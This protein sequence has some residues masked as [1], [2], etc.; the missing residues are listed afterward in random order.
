MRPSIPYCYGAIL[1]GAALICL[2]V[3]A[4]GAA[5]QNYDDESTPE[6]WAW[7]LIKQG[8]EA[9]FDVRCGTPELDPRKDDDRWNGECRRLSA[10]FISDVL[11]REP[12]RSQVPLAGINIAGTRIVDGIDLKNANLNRV[13]SLTRSRIENDIDLTRARTD[14]VICLDGSR[15]AGN[16]AGDQL[17]SDSSLWLRS[18]QF[19]KAVVLSYAKIDVNVEM[20]GT[21][22]EGP[23]EAD[24]LH[25]GLNLFLRSSDNSV[26]KFNGINLRGARIDG[27][28]SM[29]GATVEGALNADS[30]HIGAHLLMR[31]T[32]AHRA[33]FK[34]VILKNATIDGQI[35]LEG[36]TLD[37]TLNGYSLHVGSDLLMQSTDAYVAAFTE[38]VLSDA[39]IDGQIIMQGTSIGGSLNADTLHVGAHISMRSNKYT[40]VFNAIRFAN[41]QVAG[42]ISIDGAV[43][44]GDMKAAGVQVGSN[45]YMRN[46]ISPHEINLTFAHVNGNLDTSGSKLGSLDLSGASVATL[47][48][49]NVE[50]PPEVTAWQGEK[51]QPGRLNLRNAHVGNLIDAPTAWPDKGYLSLAGFTFNHLG[52]LE[53]PREGSDKGKREPGR[54][55]EWL[56]RDRTYHPSSYEQLA[57]A[58]TAAGDRA[59]ADEIRYLSRIRQR[60]VTTDWW[61]RASSY[62]FQYTAGFGIGDY[63]FLV[64]A[65]VFGI[66]FAGALYLRFLVPAGR[67]HGLVWCYGASL[68]RLLPII[69]INRE[70][71]DFFNDPERKRL[72]GRDSLIFSIIAMV[73]WLLGAILIAAVSGLVPKG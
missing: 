52:G 53:E 48:L 31:S 41:A 3:G 24:S 26:G 16:L 21:T 56:R 66:S 27:Q 69:E 35:D 38:V 14:S 36:A 46:V 49:G 55:D 30:L 10:A 1:L 25:V 7:G 22:I 50:D 12:W 51:N 15:I 47:W 17:H 59:G 6:G 2:T 65:W 58:F 60:E 4:Q 44:T 5:Q 39:R 43:L 37:G 9:N 29:I 72:T 34:N 28:V 62:L 73:G 68:S 64:L 23:L 20:T 63:T 19:K 67:E 70:F 42:Q 18:S 45:L 57:A 8:K 61:P 40:A 32:D 11:M 13:L 33:D 54:W 71:T